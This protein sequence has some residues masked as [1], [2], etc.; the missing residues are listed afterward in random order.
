MTIRILITGAQGQLGQS[1]RYL[2]TLELPGTPELILLNRH[3]LDIE[4]ADQIL[5]ALNLYTPSVLINTAAYTNVERAEQYPLR[6]HAINHKAVG[7]LAHIC[8]LHNVKLLHVSTDYVFDGFQDTPY[9]AD[10][11]PAPLNVY[12][13]SKLAGEQAALAA[14]PNCIILRT[15]WVFSQFNQNF[16]KTMLKLG[17]TT[18][19]LSIVNDEIGGPTYAVDLARVILQLALHPQA[20]GIYHFS[21]LPYVSRYE[22]AKAIFFTA[23]KY[24]VVPTPPRLQP[25]PSST[26]PSVAQRPKQVRL[27][28]Q[29]LQ[30]LNIPCMY[31]W[32]QGIQASLLA[33]SKQL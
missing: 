15:S 9:D 16:L 3:E 30:D 2:K 1:F 25:V 11:L 18:A 5:H 28:M 4:Q 12:G 6:A 7:S 13:Q 21:G 33:L 27:A 19:L 20:Q 8:A 10:A 14:L 31:P 23:Q 32:Q 17:S 22:F 29:R 26:Y 24:G